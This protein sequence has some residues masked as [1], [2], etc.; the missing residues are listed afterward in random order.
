MTAIP[1][2]LLLAQ[3][4][5][6]RPR[7]A[8]RARPKESTLH[9]A[10]AKLLRDHAL[11]DWVWFHVPNGELRDARTGARLKAMGVRPGVPDFALVSPYGSV[12][13]LELKR[14]GETLSDPQEDFRIHCIRQG[15]P[16]A[17]AYTLEEALTALDHWGCLRVKIGGVR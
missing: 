12:R 9:C 7:R 4:R 8:P 5:K 2:L 13:F 17:I 14:A 3:G 15:I 11:P 1:P 16:H 10:V 6:P